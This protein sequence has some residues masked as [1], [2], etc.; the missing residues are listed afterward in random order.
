MKDYKSIV[1][2]HFLPDCIEYLDTMN[3][4]C[5]ILKLIPKPNSIDQDVYNVLD[6]KYDILKTNRNEIVKNKELINAIKESPTKIII[7]DIGAYFA[8][9]IQENKNIAS[10]I[11]LIIEDTENGHQ[12]YEKIKTDIPVISVARSPLKEKE[13]FVLDSS[14]LLETNEE[15]RKKISK[16]W[17]E[18]FKK[19]AID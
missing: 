3:C 4:V 6:Q 18:T 9:F 15:T 8:D 2:S 7:F 19:N 1:I 14:K 13:N 10:K 17:L 11:E 16:I 12:K 5:P